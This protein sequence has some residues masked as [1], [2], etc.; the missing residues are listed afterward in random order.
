M[1][2]R[3]SYRALREGHASRRWPNDQTRMSKKA[4]EC[5][6][7]VGGHLDRRFCDHVHVCGSKGVGLFAVTVAGLIF[8]IPGYGWSRFRTLRTNVGDRAILTYPL[9]NKSGPCG[10][11]HPT[12]AFLRKPS[13]QHPLLDRME[14]VVSA[15][16][17]E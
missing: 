9:P 1:R 12:C 7:G 15:T 8:G 3:S 17:C 5:V 4:K 6:F 2:S 16:R 14:F 10:G 11:G 13:E